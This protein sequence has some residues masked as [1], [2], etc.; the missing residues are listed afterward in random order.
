MQYQQDYGLKKQRKKKQQV[1]ITFFL[2]DSEFL[3][4]K[5]DT[6]IGSEHM[7]NDKQNMAHALH[8]LILFQEHNH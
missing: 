6:V 4:V 5:E 8:Q 7:N 2:L 1:I 3:Q